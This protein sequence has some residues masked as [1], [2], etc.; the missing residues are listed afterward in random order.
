MFVS[1]RA[2]QVRI[3]PSEHY[4]YIWCCSCDALR[5]SFV[6]KLPVQLEKPVDEGKTYDIL[7]EYISGMCIIIILLFQS[8]VYYLDADEKLYSQYKV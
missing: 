8:I 4:Q 3:G 6:K 2:V 5:E 7:T 1:R